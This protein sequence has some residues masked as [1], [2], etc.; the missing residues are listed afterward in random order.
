MTPRVREALA[1]ADVVWLRVDPVAAASRT[2]ADPHRP[3]LA[4][5]P[6]VEALA[7]LLDRRAP[8]YA[9]VATWA[10]ETDGRDPDDVVAEIVALIE[11]NVR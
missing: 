10:V 11:E 9:A 4:G 5:R 6:P 3:L 1:D 7:D 2:G 8:T